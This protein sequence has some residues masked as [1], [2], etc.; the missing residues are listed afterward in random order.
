MCRFK[1]YWV[2]KKMET[3]S[4]Q[5]KWEKYYDGL[6]SL[7]SPNEYLLKCLCGKYESKTDFIKNKSWRDAFINDK[8]LDLSCGDG[9]NIILLDKLGF[10]TYATEITDSICAKVQ[11]NLIKNG[12]NIETS[13]IK[14]G[15]NNDIPFDD[16]FF[17]FVI[18]WNGIYYL[19]DDKH[20]ILDNF[21]EVHRVLKNDS[22]FI[23]SLPGPKCYSLMGATEIG[24][25][26]VEINPLVNGGWGGKLLNKTILHRFPNEDDLQKKLERYFN[27]IEISELFW[28]G[29]GV[30]LHYYIFIC[31]K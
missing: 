1:N 19:N 12:I 28:D 15:L 23:C 24:P 2:S 21:K 10:Q 14:S 16:N 31:K 7:M 6:D 18:S 20:S 22:Y 8:A 4:N 29:F 13:R 25:D 27:G 9:R 3:N 26:I 11:N 5:Y 17:N 30:P